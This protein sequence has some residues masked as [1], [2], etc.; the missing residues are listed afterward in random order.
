[1]K[2]RAK[3]GFYYNTDDNVTVLVSKDQ[4]IDVPDKLGKRFI[5]NGVARQVKAGP[6]ERKVVSPSKQKGDA[7]GG[8]NPDK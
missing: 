4:E 1:M 5:R 3:T 2:I 7:D 6:V 8:F